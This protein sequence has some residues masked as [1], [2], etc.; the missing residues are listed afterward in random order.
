VRKRKENSAQQSNSRALKRVAFLSI[1]VL[2]A[3]ENV[4]TLHA[5]WHSAPS[6]LA[7]CARR[8]GYN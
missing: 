1:I 3:R 4:C 8:F 2:E 7:Q 6:K 5:A